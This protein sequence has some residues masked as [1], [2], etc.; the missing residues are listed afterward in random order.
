M[1]RAI[2]T[3]L[4]AAFRRAAVPLTVYFGVTLGLPLANGAAAAGAV[5]REHALVVLVVP[6]L[7]VTVFCAIRHS[8]RVLASRKKRKRP[9]STR[10]PAGSDSPGR[11]RYGSTRT[12]VVPITALV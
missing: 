11:L 7:V 9:A 4:A 5:F 6:P 2:G 1:S 10:P 12:I 8:S 3:A